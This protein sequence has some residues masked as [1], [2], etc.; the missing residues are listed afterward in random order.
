MAR[1]GKA[2]KEDRGR[3]GVRDSSVRLHKAPGQHFVDDQI[4]LD[5][6]PDVE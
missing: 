2:G 3:F 5:V 4:G 6:S 1:H